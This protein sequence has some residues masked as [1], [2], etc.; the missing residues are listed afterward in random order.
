[1]ELK[2]DKLQS[3]QTPEIWV[4]IQFSS[5]MILTLRFRMC[6]LEKILST[7]QHD[8]RGPDSTSSL[9]SSWIST[10]A[11]RRLT[12]SHSITTATDM[13]ISV[14]AGNNPTQRKV[15]AISSRSMK[16]TKVAHRSESTPPNALEVIIPENSPPLD[17]P[18]SGCLVWCNIHRRGHLI[19]VQHRYVR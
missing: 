19:T 10:C 1:M 14:V 18:F 13:Y 15:R 2:W 9:M 11:G 4:V 7:N 5:G 12:G 16:P 6:G 17:F 3:F 8:G